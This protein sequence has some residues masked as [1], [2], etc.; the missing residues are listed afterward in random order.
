[1]GISLHGEKMGIDLMDY[2]GNVD[3]GK[4][5]RCN[6]HPQPDCAQWLKVNIYIM[7]TTM[8]LQ[9]NPSYYRLTF[10]LY[11]IYF[12]DSDFRHENYFLVFLKACQC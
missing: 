6:T 9:R 5:C 8:L 12:M 4:Y 11:L 10:F 7:G 1:M 2:L 3:R